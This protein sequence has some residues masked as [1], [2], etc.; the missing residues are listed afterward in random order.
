MS[1]FQNHFSLDV[2]LQKTLFH[3]PSPAFL[4]VKM[5]SPEKHFP[6]G[7]VIFKTFVLR[8]AWALEKR[9]ACSRSHGWQVAL[10]IGDPPSGILANNITSI[11]CL[12]QTP[13][14]M[15]EANFRVVIAFL[16]A[17]QQIGAPATQSTDS[18]LGF[19]FYAYHSASV[20]LPPGVTHKRILMRVEGTASRGGSG[21][22][23]KAKVG[24][25]PCCSRITHVAVP[26][27]YDAGPYEAGKCMSTSL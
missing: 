27:S 24:Y 23:L 15:R 3:C 9:N 16:R 17:L 18:N 7:K 25:C 12:K 20:A 5:S 22:S 1:S 4:F 8:R 10:R 26:P 11:T 21:A 19:A 2:F 13:P 6:W 14:G